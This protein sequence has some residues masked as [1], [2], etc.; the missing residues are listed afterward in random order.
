MEKF[1]PQLNLK[2]IQELFFIKELI[3]EDLYGNY[4][5]IGL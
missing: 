2:K 1:M 5:L 3:L 4:K